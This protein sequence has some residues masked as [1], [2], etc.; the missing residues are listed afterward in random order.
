MD[1]N[2]HPR[3][4]TLPYKLPATYGPLFTTN[5]RPLATE[6]AEIVES[7]RVAGVM[8][9]SL[10][11]QITETR[12]QLHR[13]EREEMHA[14]RHIERCKYP[15]API[16]RV[17][18]EIL[19]NIFTYYADL[20]KAI[21]FSNVRYG[22]WVLG[23]VCGHWRAVALTTQA[24]WS[25][26][27]FT[28][29]PKMGNVGALAE[30][31]LMRSGNHP[32]SID[33]L[34]T[35]RDPEHPAV[36]DP[37]R[38]VFDA[39]L[40][41]SREW[42]VAH[43][44]LPPSLYPDMAI[45]KGNLPS[46]RKL[47]LSVFRLDF[48]GATP[49]LA[50]LE[51]FSICPRLVDLTLL[52]LTRGNSHIVFPWAQLERYSGSDRYGPINVL[53]AAPNIRECRLVN[54]RVADNEFNTPIVHQMHSLEL[55]KLSC[56]FLTTPALTRLACPVAQVNFVHELLLRSAPPLA[57]LELIGFHAIPDAIVRQ[58]MNLFAVAPAIAQLTLQ[59]HQREATEPG[60]AAVFAG[61]V[62]APTNGDLILPALTH[63]TMSG[64]AFDDAFVRM[65]ASRC[66][67]NTA[68]EPDMKFRRLKAVS[69]SAVGDTS[70]SHLLRLR[71]F[72]VQNGLELTIGQAPT[73]RMRDLD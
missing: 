48:G 10:Q 26:F 70:A 44:R 40:V 54:Y 58:L 24:I 27:V 55:R 18:T 25:S 61:L 36:G 62:Y 28:C 16:R 51:A 6:L 64:I 65:V 57:A 60:A 66:V 39:L 34:C 20:V 46:L 1:G 17:P 31:Y 30:E 33:F 73:L 47:E 35:D 32:L 50:A 41:R 68:S 59:G 3:G 69:V 2:Y 67:L 22:V 71:Q 63:F 52:L 9:A 19:V 5:D 53:S 56:A 43:F 23:H 11:I 4:T 12:M 45:I 8:K 49:S 15:L 13:L 29:S 7:A 38:D 42:E 21:K 72:E 14:A 37:C